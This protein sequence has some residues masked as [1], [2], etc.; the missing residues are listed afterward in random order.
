MTRETAYDAAKRAFNNRMLEHATRIRRDPSLSGKTQTVGAELSALVNHET[1]YAWP[2]Q[3][4]LCD[5]L[6]MPKRTIKWAIARLSEAGYFEITKVGLNNRYRPIEEVQQGQILPL[7]ERQQ[8]QA[9]PLVEE[10]RGKNAPNKGQESTPARGKNVPPTLLDTFLNTFPPADARAGGAAP[11]GAAGPSF[12]LGLPGVELRRKL[13]DDVFGSW[14]GKVAIVAIEEDE[15]V[16]QAP[17]RFVAD[18]LVSNY[19]GPILAAWRLEHPALARLRTIVAPT[20]IAARRPE[21]PD[22]CWLGEVGVDL[23]R[24]RMQVSKKRAAEAVTNWLQRCKSPSGLRRILVEADQLGNIG[25]RDQFR[26][27]VNDRTRRML[28]DEQRPMPFMLGP[29]AV[30]RSAS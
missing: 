1:G 25:T 3:D 17:T 20:P 12:D 18:K 16:L 2:S 14:L 15:L 13:G 19:E 9:L 7:L 22:I 24:R 29:Q 10:T 28:Q 27:V 5:L 21:D 6:G 11:D 4:Y 8:G 23:V 26:N 30:K